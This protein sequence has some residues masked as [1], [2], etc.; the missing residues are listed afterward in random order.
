MK[1]LTSTTLLFLLFFGLL[2]CSEEE[3]Q[4]CRVTNVTMTV[5]G[6]VQTFQAIGRG[7]SLRQSGYELQLNFYRGSSSP[8]REQSIA[9]KLPY[10]KTGNNIIEQFIYNQYIDNVAFSGDFV[11]GEL[12]SKVITNTSKCFYATFSGQLNDGNQ[13]VVITDGSI[14]YEYEESFDD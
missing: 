7:I 5:N 3:E 4:T 2:A 13:V 12:Q 10:K 11:E 6:E 1:N 14:S 9:M 8:F